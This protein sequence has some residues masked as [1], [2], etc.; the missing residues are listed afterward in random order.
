MTWGEFKKLAEERGARDEQV[1][2]Y[3]DIG[4]SDHWH[5]NVEK[6]PIADN[7]PVIRLSII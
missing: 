7:D 3:I 2:Q 1:I 6:A 4:A 5:V